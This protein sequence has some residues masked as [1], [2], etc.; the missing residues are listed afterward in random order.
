MLS[1]VLNVILVLLVLGFVARYIYKM[2]KF[3]DGELA[4]S[5]ESVLMDGEAFKL[6]DLKGQYVLIDFWGSWCGPCRRE[7]PGLVK[8]HQD[9]NG[10]SF[11]DAKGFEILNIGIET[12]E[13]RWKQAIKKDGLNW[14][15]HIL[16]AESFKSP[17]AKAYGIVEIPTKYFIGP[18][19]NILLVNPAISEISDYLQKQQS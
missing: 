15:Y 18:D 3:D 11:K 7:N 17:I 14:K 5:I 6:S 9:F 1:K 13:A 8:L 12:K 16:Q 2:P 4:P 10:K 19:G